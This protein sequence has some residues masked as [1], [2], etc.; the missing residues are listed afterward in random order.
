MGRAAFLLIL[1]AV[2]GACRNLDVPDGTLRCSANER[3]PSP[4]TCHEGFCYRTLPG[5]GGQGGGSGEGGE[6]GSDA[7]IA[8]QGG[9]GNAGTGGLG[10]TGALAPDGGSAPHDA[11]R[12]ADVAPTC[13]PVAEDC[14]NGRDDDCDEMVDC[15]DRDC[16]QGAVCVPDA[17]AGFAAGVGVAATASCPEGYRGGET[18]LHRSL[19]TKT[20][21]TGC[22]CEVSKTVCEP[23]VFGYET[24]GEC[25]ADT[26]N[27][28]GTPFML[29]TDYNQ[30]QSISPGFPIRGARLQSVRPVASCQARGATPLPSAPEWLE[31]KKFCAVE[32]ATPR[33]KGCPEGYSCAQRPSA[34]KACVLSASIAENCPAPFGSAYQWFTGFA[35][36]R[37]CGP[38]TCEVKGGACRNPVVGIYYGYLCQDNTPPLFSIGDTVANRV[39]SAVEYGPMARYL[40]DIEPAACASYSSVQSGAA[41]A[42]NMR[43]YCC[44]P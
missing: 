23:S 20:E 3:C 41:T 33:G 13:T 44:L 38:C 4:Y 39:C 9:G 37:T 26:N 17:P 12:K 29:T 43:R 5:D 1:I 11:Q 10:G 25:E 35:D 14:W 28:G 2:A 19:S 6:G 24:V 36:N 34:G 42:T 40:G 27:T 31:S 8:G 30:C 7:A 21:C 18:V 22:S 15:E 16:E 32:T